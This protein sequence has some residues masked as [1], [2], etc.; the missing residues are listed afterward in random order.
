MKRITAVIAAVL[1]TVIS[2]SPC[3]FA[4][5]SA[6]SITLNLIN[7]ADKNP[8]AN[9]TQAIR[10]ARSPS[11]LFRVNSLHRASISSSPAPRSSSMTS[12][13]P[14]HRQEPKSNPIRRASQNLKTALW[15]LI[16]YIHPISFSIPLSC[17]FRCPVMTVSRLM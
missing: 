4:A 9:K 15:E 7:K 3:A 13:S 17:L 12:S 11:L 14:I 5:P 16:L 1:L 2:F 10:P 6:G 8:L